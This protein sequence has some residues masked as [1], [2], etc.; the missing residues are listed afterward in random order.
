MKKLI[1]VL[2]L[3]M[4]MSCQT[5]QPSKLLYIDE[6]KPSVTPQLFAKGFI[7]KDSVAE[8][9]SVF[10]KKGDEFF[11]AIDSGGKAKINYTTI[12]NGKWLEP[13]TIIVDSV[14]SFNDPFLSPDENKLYYISD[15]PK[16]RLDTLSDYDIWYSERV[17]QKWSAPIN[18]G[19]NINSDGN[20]FYISFTENGSMYFASNI[21]SY[22]GR[23]HNLD[24]YKSPMTDK[25]FGKPQKLSDAINS[26][27]Y[28]ADVFVSPDESYIIY[29]AAR[30]S[31]LGRGDLY[32]SFKDENDA[33]TKSVNMGK[34]I[35]SEGNEICPYVSSDGKYFFYTSNQDIY[36]VSTEIFDQI[37]NNNE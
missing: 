21:E 28:E 19:P 22:T 29:C 6:N 14:Y 32:I 10:N 20:E 37:R 34:P 30:R 18:A 11:Y 36:W 25:G 1:N 7:T 27:G 33:W 26:K 3:L 23:K 12:K 35:N 15:W 4:L 13:V 24:I 16:G 2:L 31:G 17:G 8:F 9:G 5:E